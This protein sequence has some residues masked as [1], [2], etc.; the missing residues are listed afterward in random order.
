[1]SLTLL[2]LGTGDAFSALHHSCCNA[3][4]YEE[5]GARTVLLVDC[6][7]PPRKVLK[8]AARPGVAPLDVGDLSAVLLTHLHADHA[9][10]VEGLLWY[11]RFVLGKKAV[12]ALHDEVRADLWEHHLKGSMGQLLAPDGSTLPLSLEL[13]ADTVPLREAVAVEVGPFRVE[14]RRTRHHIPTFAVRVSAGGACVAFSAD[15]GWDEALLA[16][17]LEADLVVHEAGHGPGHTPLER[18]AA[19]PAAT[20]ARMR[21]THLGDEVDRDVLPIT[22]LREGEPVLVAR[23]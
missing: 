3:V 7:H 22:P 19:L 17:L 9:S 5:G 4:I 14:L 8:D 20:R 12:L 15:T 11:S 2:P 23:R 16:W 13:L 21:L 18:L 6:P 1:M 10:G